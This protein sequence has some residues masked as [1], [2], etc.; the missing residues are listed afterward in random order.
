M[1]ALIRLLTADGLQPV[2]YSAESLAEAAAHEP[3]D[4]V[5]T[6][7]NTFDTYN[8]LRLDAHL[9]RMEDSARRAGM[10]LTLDRPR[11]RAALRQLITEA[12][13]GDVR[14]RVTAARQ[15]P[16]TLIL[17]VEPFKPLA[18]ALIEAGVRVITVPGSA[19]HNPAAKTTD[20]MHQRTRIADTLPPGIYDAILL[21]DDGRLLEGLAANFY[22]IK[23]T[24]PRLYTAGEGVLPGIAQQIVFAVAP[25]ILPL[26]RTAV[27]V[28]DI[29]QLAE[30]FITSSSRGIVPVVEIDG[31]T[32]GDG[33]PGPLTRALRE[34]Y[35][36]WVAAHVEPL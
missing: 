12:G 32:L 20:W 22:A 4:G 31:H 23:D 25:D 15:Q 2:A 17:S 28:A 30:A 1:P 13:Y 21:D 3:D 18:A 27:T 24:P 11:L 35:Q 14:F 8:V 33:R 6:V 9:D 7:T 10:T 16:D 36:A 5:Y 19:R 34:A 26:V 29:P